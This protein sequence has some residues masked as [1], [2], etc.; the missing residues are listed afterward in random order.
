M[1]KYRCVKDLYLDDYDDDG[2]ATGGWTYIPVGSIWEVDE[3]LYRIVGGNDTIHLDLVT[4]ESK[5][6]WIEILYST[7]KEH[8]ELIN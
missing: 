1:E 7:L 5:Y 6:K 3:S 4:E 2:F 8:F